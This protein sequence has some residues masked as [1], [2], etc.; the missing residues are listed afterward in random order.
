MTNLR[1]SEYY[2]NRVRRFKKSAHEILG[3]ICVRCGFSDSRALQID[4]INGNGSKLRKKTSSSYE[5]YKDVI[6]SVSNGENKYQLLCANCNWIKR[7][8]NKEQLVSIYEIS[9]KD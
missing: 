4:H 8:E 6:K 3:G 9:N 1:V 2:F 7:F 5:L